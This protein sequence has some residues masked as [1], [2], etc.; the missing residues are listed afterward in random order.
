MAD[1]PK[2]GSFVH[3]EFAVKD[4]AAVN[5]VKDFY[6]PI[7]GWKFTDVPEFDYTLFEA[8]SGPGGG[9]GA[10]QPGQNVGITNYLSVP[11][12]DETVKKIEKAGGKV[13]GPKIEVPGQGWLINFLDPAGVP[14]A[15][16]QSTPHE[17]PPK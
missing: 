6:G 13:L 12:I 5:K 8:R 2:P 14:M 10:V 15:L 3:V 9:I 16:W 1:E 17:H 11:S 4:A 7:F